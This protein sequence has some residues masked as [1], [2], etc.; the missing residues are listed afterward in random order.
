MTM[1][2]VIILLI[3][4]NFLRYNFVS[5]E[6]TISDKDWYRY[7]NNTGYFEVINFKNNTFN[8]NRPDDNN[9]Q[10]EYDNCKKYYFNKKDKEF[11]FDCG[12]SIRI[13]ELNKNS[14]DMIIDGKNKIFF[15]DIEKSINYEF[16]SYFGKSMEEFKKNKAQAK[17]FIKINEKKLFEVIG[18]DEFSKILFIGNNCSSVDCILALDILEKWIAKTENVYY[19]DVNDLNNNILGKLNKI[20]N[21][22]LK[23]YNFYDNIYPRVIITKKNSLVDQYEIKCNGFNCNK[24]NSNEF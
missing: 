19:F 17:D 1:L 16:E 21:S 11:N 18:S 9:V 3:I 5:I 2:I 6:K 13:V 12:K 10:N 15:D 14:V 4:T 24:Y 23:D 8:Y 20:N 7:D 22:L